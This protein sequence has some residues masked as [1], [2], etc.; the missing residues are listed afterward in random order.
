MIGNLHFDADILE[1]LNQMGIEVLSF[2]S[3]SALLLEKLP[4]HHKDPFDRIIITQAISNDY[5]IITANN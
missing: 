5:K 1:L 4:L 3:K 2:D